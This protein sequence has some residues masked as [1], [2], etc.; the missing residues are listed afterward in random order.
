MLGNHL[1]GY[2]AHALTTAPIH[3]VLIVFADSLAAAAISI[4]GFFVV[5]YFLFQGAHAGAAA[6][7]E[8]RRP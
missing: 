3:H 4:T 2:D 8:R 5:L 7:T 1:L 6:Q